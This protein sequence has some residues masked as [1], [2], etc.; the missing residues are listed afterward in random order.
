[1]VGQMAGCSGGFCAGD[2][3]RFVIRFLDA[4]AGFADGKLWLEY[5]N[6]AAKWSEPVFPTAVCGAVSCP[7]PNLI[8]GKL[9]AFVLNAGVRLAQKQRSA[10]SRR[11]GSSFL[12]LLVI[13]TAAGLA[14]LWWN[15]AKTK[16]K[17]RST[18]KVSAATVPP[19]STATT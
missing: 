11:S 4:C 8:L 17:P 16:T 2:V 3:G 9:A 6:C 5:A 19:L 1:A 18:T 14:W 10:R 15:A 12:W 7:S 13:L